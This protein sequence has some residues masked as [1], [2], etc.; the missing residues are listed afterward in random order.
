[1]EFLSVGFCI[2]G[3]DGPAP[4]RAFSSSSNG[5]E[6]FS[7]IDA[8]YVP[9]QFVIGNVAYSVGVAGGLF[10]T[11]SLGRGE[12]KEFSDVFNATRHLAL[13]RICAEARAAGA[14][15]VIGIETRIMPFRGVH[16]M[17]M[18]GTAAYHP[19]LGPAVQNTAVPAHAL[20]D[21]HQPV[22]GH[23]REP[24]DID[25]ALVSQFG[26][27]IMEP[28]RYQKKAMECIIAAGRLT[29]GPPWPSPRTDRLPGGL[30]SARGAGV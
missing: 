25:I 4:P 17:L 21:R 28:H 7:L 14:N 9:K 3:S 30:S 15:A 6:L 13:R 24:S 18:L 20:Q 10:G 1:M 5:Q 11:L 8:G 29:A 22:N 23:F 27:R 16:E 2:H 26:R 19:A 12:I